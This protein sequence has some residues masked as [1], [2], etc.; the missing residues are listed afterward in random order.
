MTFWKHKTNQ[1]WKPKKMKIKM[2]AGEEAIAYNLPDLLLRQ[3]TNGEKNI[4]E[5]PLW[6]LERK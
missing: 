1:L 6:N 2:K 3:I 4:S 5:S